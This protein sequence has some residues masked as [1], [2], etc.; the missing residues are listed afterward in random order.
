MG[1]NSLKIIRFKSRINHQECVVL[2]E[3]GSTHNFLNLGI[4]REAKLKVD[5]DQRLEIIV[6]NGERVR[7]EGKCM[8][9]KIKLQGSEFAVKA[10][11]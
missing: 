4:M 10:Y 11:V 9:V 5:I 8:D 1:S 6:A 3:N 2:I 7:N